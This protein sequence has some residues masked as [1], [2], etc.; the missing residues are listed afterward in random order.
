MIT[1][2]YIYFHYYNW[3][4]ARYTLHREN[5]YYTWKLLR[6]HREFHFQTS[7]GTVNENFTVKGPILRCKKRQECE[8]KGVETYYWNDHVQEA[9][10][11]G[12]LTVH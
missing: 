5:Y 7:V 4:I 9:G 6:K 11:V 2:F 12:K 1:L 10:K 8:G 3:N